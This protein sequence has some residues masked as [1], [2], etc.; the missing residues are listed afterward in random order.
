MK[1]VMYAVPVS[2]REI[3]H[4]V[5]WATIVNGVMVSKGKELLLTVRAAAKLCH[6]TWCVLKYFISYIGVHTCP[7]TNL[8]GENPIFGDFRTQNRQF[9]PRHSLMR[10]KSSNL[11]Q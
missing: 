10:E 11:K 8:R 2:A 9:E 7:L 3:G 6:T 4:Q 5:R 1:L